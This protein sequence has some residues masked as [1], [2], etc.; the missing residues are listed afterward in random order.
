MNMLRCYA[1]V[2]L[3]LLV[4]GDL[5]C[6][7]AE[8]QFQKVDVFPAGMHGVTLYRI[9]GI[10]VTPKGT[11]LAYC[12]ARRDSR[13]D[14]G[15][16]EIH[17][18][19]SLDGGKSWL[20][21]Q[22]IA[23]HGQRMEGNPRK[24]TGGETEQ[25]VNNPVAIVDH[26]TGAIEF[27]YCLNYARCFSIRSQ[28]DGETWSQ[29]V[30]ITQTFKPFR[31][32]YPWK[33][34]A[35]GPGHGSQLASGR[36][37]V[38][39]W[40]AYG[41]VGDHSPS[42]CGTIYSDDHGKTWKAGEVAVPNEGIFHHPNESMLATFDDGQVMLITRSVSE[43]NR[44][45]VTKSKTGIGDWGTPQFH[46]QLLEPVCMASILSVPS[47]DGD[48]ELVLFTNPHSVARDK[49]GEEVPAGRGKRRNLTI[50]LSRDRGATW[51]VSR[52]IDE[53]PSA[54]SDL[55]FLPDGTILC[56]YEGD[57]TIACARMNLEWIME[58]K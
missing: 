27:L 45:I 21:A 15:E 5:L 26:H 38:P 14:W 40:M 20:P 41:D 39:V 1:L 6:R 12:E 42:F 19:R 7:A 36:L 43:P 49:K 37:L 53:G 25:T 11:V 18:R 56:L 31:S 28:D 57:K 48:E 47:R 52:T 32:R 23:H 13:A 30:E 4:S 44:K 51:E 9:P 22:H 10:V 54:Y 50:K 34:I 33:V 29:P 35:T 8:P 58:S 55:A 16:I 46:P 3:A 2:S 17:L 24:K